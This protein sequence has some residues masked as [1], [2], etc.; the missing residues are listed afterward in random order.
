MLLQSFARYIHANPLRLGP[1]SSALRGLLHPR[2]KRPPKAPT[3]MESWDLGY[4]WPTGLALACRSAT[5][6]TLYDGNKYQAYQANTNPGTLARSK[7]TSP[8]PPR[9][10]VLWADPVWLLARQTCHEVSRNISPVAA[11]RSGVISPKCEGL[12]LW[13]AVFRP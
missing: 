1:Q 12:L 7:A 5:L 13:I 6:L 4:S 3:T 10:A 8:P 9:F 2:P 11:G